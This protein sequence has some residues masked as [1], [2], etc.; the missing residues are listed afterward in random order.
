MTLQLASCDEQYKR[1]PELDRAEVMKLV[2]WQEKQPHLPPLSGT[3]IAKFHLFW[4]FSLPSSL[5]SSFERHAILNDLDYCWK[6]HI[7]QIF[8]EFQFE[9]ES[10]YSMRKCWLF[11]VNQAYHFKILTYISNSNCLCKQFQARFSDFSCIPC[12]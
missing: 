8:W 10:I 12:T 7:W 11:S 1:F 4:L 6:S 9:I 2:E 5:R 3:S